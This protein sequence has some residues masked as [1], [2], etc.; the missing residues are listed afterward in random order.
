MTRLDV[1]DT[2][3]RIKVC[4]AYKIDGKTVDNFPADIEALAKAQPV[5]EELPGW[6]KPIGDVRIFKEL[7]FKAQKYVKRIEELIGSP[8]SIIGV[9]K[10]RE[11]TIQRQSVF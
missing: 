5:Y 8:V 1:L 10:R 3:P 2:L 11:Q 7:P 6:E 9:G 4:T